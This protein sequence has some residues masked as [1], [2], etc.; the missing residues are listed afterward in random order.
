MKTD[1][2]FRL[3]VNCQRLAPDS[4]SRFFSYPLRVQEFHSFGELKFT[5]EIEKSDNTSSGKVSDIE[6]AYYK[7]GGNV[8]AVRREFTK[9][10]NQPLKAQNNKTTRRAKTPQAQETKEVD[11]SRGISKKSLIASARPHSTTSESW[12]AEL[13]DLG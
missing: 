1:R 13:L 5:K 3:C 9:K 8:A 6:A 7:H 12:R 2:R 11:R 10:R 4:F